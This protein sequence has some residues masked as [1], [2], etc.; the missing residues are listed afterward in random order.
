MVSLWVVGRRFFVFEEFCDCDCDCD[1]VVDFFGVVWGFWFKL[2]RMETLAMGSAVAATGLTTRVASQ[3]AV[4]S[5]TTVS[6][7]F[8]GKS[9]RLKTSL[10]SAVPAQQKFRAIRADAGAQT[11]QVDTKA[12]AAGRKA[13]IKDLPEKEFQGKTV[14]VRADLNVPLDKEGVITDDTRIRAS[15]P[16]IEYLVKNGAKVVLASHL[17]RPKKGPEDKFSLKPV[18]GMLPLCAISSD[19]GKIL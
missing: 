18:A 10:A 4:Q 14:F 12:Q 2:C 17:G 16:T 9:L 7:A 6:S 11:A 5:R 15:I 1:F 13:N 3:A 19:C 8:V